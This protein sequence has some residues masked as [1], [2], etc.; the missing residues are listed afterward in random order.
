M[1]LLKTIALASGCLAVSTAA[2]H[3]QSATMSQFGDPY[4]ATALARGSVPPEGPSKA[5]KA[6][7]ARTSANKVSQ[8][9]AKE[10]PATAN[11]LGTAAEGLG[12]P[13]TAPLPQLA[14]PPSTTNSALGLSLKWSAENDPYY[15]AA[16][17]TVPAID[18]IRRDS[19]QTPGEAGS[20]IQAGVNLKF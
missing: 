3:A 12:E 18:E 16:T 11:R 1:R 9:A 14:A 15:N 7:A 5:A 4:D 10:L 19:N 2:V 6:A 17:S 13:A 20:S 8:T